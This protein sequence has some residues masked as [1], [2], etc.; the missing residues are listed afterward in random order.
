MVVALVA[1]F[2]VVTASPALAACTSNFAGATLTLSCSGV[3]TVGRTVDGDITVNGV[4]P[5]G[6]P[7]VLDTDLIVVNGGTG[8]NNITIDMTNGRFLPGLTSE[9]DDSEIEWQI[10][11]VARVRSNTFR[12]VGQEGFDDF[13]AAGAGGVNLNGDPDGAQTDVTLTSISLVS[14]WGQGGNDDIR[15]DGTGNAPGGPVTRNVSIAGGNGND[16]LAGGNGGDVLSGEA[17]DDRLRGF[18]G[19]DVLNGGTGINTLDYSG[20]PASVTVDVGASTASGGHADGDTLQTSGGAPTF[21]NVSG[22]SLDDTLTGDAN[23]NVL[24]GQGGN[25]VLIGLGEADLLFG[26]TD[27]DSIS[28]AA[29]PQGVDVDLSANTGQGGHAQGDTYSGIEA[30][31]GSPGDDRIVGSS[32]ANVLQ[33]GPG[34]DLLIGLVGPD[35]LDGDDGRDR[36]TYAASPDAVQVDGSDLVAETGGHAEG[37]LVVEVEDLEGSPQGDDLT[38]NAAANLLIG[39]AGQDALAGL[40]EDDTLVGGADGDSLD[41]GDDTDTLDYSGSGAGVQVNLATGA[42]S[43]GDATGDTIAAAENII[44]SPLDDTLTGDAAANRFQG[45]FGS[46]RLTGG[47]G[48]NVLTGGQGVDVVIGGPQN[49]ALAGGGGNDKL[50]PGPGADSAAGGPG[51]D[52][53]SFAASTAGITLDLQ[54]QT[55]VGQGLDDL[56]AI[57][58]AIGSG[59]ADDLTGNSEANKLEALDGADHIEGLGGPDNLIGGPGSDEL[60]GGAG[61]DILNGGAGADTCDPGPD[62]GQQISC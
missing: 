24:S 10:N 62:G 28:Y 32:A 6:S 44:G 33:A 12:V 57:E 43:G 23:P 5:S 45:E 7:D 11:G 13:I 41:G 14:I 59:L 58:N 39:G 25:D 19:G 35:L 60:L 36:T 42:A 15:A 17:G 37:D 52:T 46:D 4:V 1:A 51:I 34:D 31:V 27:V 50:T 38:G 49:D 56:D 29:S 26:S 40:E 53:V 55:A 20:S 47:G 9:G 16:L 2:V 8:F 21:Q 61:F 3:T 30:V 54:T 48:P 18:A 22:S